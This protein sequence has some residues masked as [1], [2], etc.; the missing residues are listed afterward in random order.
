MGYFAGAPAEQAGGTG[1]AGDVTA[2]EW[3]VITSAQW[4][5]L[6]D[7]GAFVASSTKGADGTITLKMAGD[8]TQIDGYR[9][10][11]AGF[12]CPLL[13]L[14]PDWDDATDELQLYLE[15]A[16][17]EYTA[18]KY[19]LFVGVADEVYASRATQEALT[20]AVLPSTT[21]VCQTAQLGSGTSTVGNNGTNLDRPLGLYARLHW[22]D[23]LQGRMSYSADRSVLGH[24]EG[25]AV[26]AAS[27]VMNAIGSRYV[28]LG[29]VHVS[30][31][32]GTPVLAGRVWHRRLRNTADRGATPTLGAKPASVET[33]VIVG[34]SIANG[35]GAA[36][37]TYGGAAVPVGITL[38]DAGATAATYPNNAGAGPEP[39]VL[40]YW[41]AEIGTGTIIRRATNGQ[42]LAGLESTELPGLLDDCIAL[43]ID[44]STVDLCV[45]MIGE[46]DSQ[47]STESDAYTA[48]LD[49]TCRLYEQA[50][51]QARILIQNQ[52][53]EDASYAQFAAIRAA[54]AAAA[55]VN[56]SRRA[57]VSH[58]GITLQDAVHYNLAGYATAAAAQIA[59]WDA[60]A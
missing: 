18:A 1:A 39:G 55:A 34:H 24:V 5:S 54:N 49:Q 52:V 32:S 9:E 46:N 11:Y 58:A 57:V 53:S 47:N 42:I 56:P 40:P 2:T 59:A 13:D 3:A 36:D 10:N 27:S 14:Y 37:G 45:L 38:R 50:F 51:P 12:Y 43:G 35:Y 60:L 22:D 19:G 29:H 15:I 8:V 26:A 16:A 23:A 20:A 7:A 28:V 30:V 6:N 33:M 17:L 31:V 25:N 48:R 41:A 21:S 4:G 44:R